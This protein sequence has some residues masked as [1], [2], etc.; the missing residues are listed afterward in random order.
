MDASSKDY[1]GNVTSS[2]PLFF[3]HNPPK[4]LPENYSYED[5][6]HSFVPWNQDIITAL[7]G[8][9]LNQATYDVKPL[10]TTNK[11]VAFF[12]DWDFPESHISPLM[13]SNS[14]YDNFMTK[15][16]DEVF[17]LHSYFG[18]SFLV[19]ESDENPTVLRA[20]VYLRENPADFIDFLFTERYPDEKFQYVPN[21]DFNSKNTLEKLSQVDKE[22][23]I[24]HFS[25]FLDWWI[26][27]QLNNGNIY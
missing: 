1:I 26:K 5:S 12:H 10:V 22:L 7:D 14:N 11:P 15:L 13:N 18:L 27:I 17:D 9:N 2:N 19:D 16:K 24:I 3:L 6:I 21:P 20:K 8:L 4:R 23:E 25:T